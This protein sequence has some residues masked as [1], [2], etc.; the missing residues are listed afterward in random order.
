MAIIIMGLFGGISLAWPLENIKEHSKSVLAG[1][2]GWGIGFIV[3]GLLSYP[4][5]LYR[6]YLY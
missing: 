5:Y 3:G 4:L 6:Y 1:F 2:L